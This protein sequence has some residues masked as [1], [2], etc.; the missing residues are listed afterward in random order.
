MLL[1]LRATNVPDG[2]GWYLKQEIE[3]FAYDRCQ[4]F[5]QSFYLNGDFC[6][7]GA[8][9]RDITTKVC[10]SPAHLM[11]NFANGRAC[12]RMLIELR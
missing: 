11:A 3:I 8:Q 10:D 4:A 1:Q 9:L 12:R 6:Y 2:R 5:V 7:S